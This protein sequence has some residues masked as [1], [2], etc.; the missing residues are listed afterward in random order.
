MTQ[1]NPLMILGRN[2]LYTSTV[3]SGDLDLAA[4]QNLNA[5][6]ADPGVQTVVF[7]RAYNITMPRTTQVFAGNATDVFRL[8]AGLRVIGDPTRPI[9]ASLWSTTADGTARYLFS[10]RGTEGGEVSVTGDLLRGRR[11]I[12]I[13]SEG[14]A[15]LALQRGDRV[16][17][18][19]NKLFI[20]GTTVGTEEQGEIVT[21]AAVGSTSF[22]T[23]SPLQ[24][25]YAVS[26]NARVVKQSPMAGIEMEGVRAIGA[27][28][29]STS[30]SAAVA[31]DRM[32][33]MVMCQGL[34]LEELS[35]EFM[36]GG[37]FIYSSDGGR[38]TR[39]KALFETTDAATRNVNQYGLALVNACQD[40]IVDQ[41]DIKGGKHGVVQTESSLVRGVTR[42][43]KVIDSVVSGTWNYA[44]PVHTNAEQWTVERNVM[45]GCSGGI[46][47][48][49]RSVVSR[50]NEVRFT[51][52]DASVLG[53]GLGITEICEDVLSE[54]DRFY[55]GGFGV[56]LETDVAPALVAGSVGPTKIRLKDTYI[57]D[58]NQ[59]GIRIEWTGA[60][61]RADIEL[62]NISTRGIGRP[63][64]VGGYPTS[65]AATAASSI[66]IRGNASGSLTRVKID[67]ANLQGWAGNSTACVV[68][69]FC[70][71]V[72]A[73]GIS[74][75]DHA[76][77]SIGTTDVVTADNNE[78]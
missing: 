63:V 53:V 2:T 46:E 27:G 10:A 9:D 69:Q 65:G 40:F 55:G 68:T 18:T 73:T 19:S 24:D 28:M 34:V 52:Y 17:I 22:D 23:F 25:D 14:I 4:I 58:A 29:L 67:G 5:A 71:G 13:G 48:G 6:I 8:K 74:Y 36:D 50:N 47:A 31:G 30:A 60:G 7:D 32:L 66:D 33:H 21:V 76:A 3:A 1:L 42:R 38:A 35:S 56:R 70:T 15:A 61:A 37:S 26:D 75:A 12:P 64:D 11:S 39:F 43:C 59:D 16:R 51:R 20:A 57:E 41:A 77:P 44:L 72:H 49:C 78:F 62:T 45:L 54:G